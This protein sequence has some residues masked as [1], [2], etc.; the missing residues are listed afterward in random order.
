MDEHSLAARVVMVLKRNFAS[1]PLAWPVLSV[2]L[3]EPISAVCCRE[4]RIGVE[5]KFDGDPGG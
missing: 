1:L 4:I 3:R 5:E 2:M